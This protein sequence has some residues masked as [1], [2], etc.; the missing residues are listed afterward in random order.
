MRSLLSRRQPEFPSPDALIA[1]ADACVDR[2]LRVQRPSG[3][4]LYET[5]PNGDLQSEADSLVRQAGCAYALGYA[6]KRCSDATRAGSIFAA[7]ARTLCYL[8]DRAEH[9]AAGEFFIP[10]PGQRRG[11]LGTIALA[12]L[13]FHELSAPPELETF[14][15]QAAETIRSAQRPDGSFRCWLGDGKLPADGSKANYY[16][17]EAL[18]AL[19]RA[20]EVA[21]V[22]QS[23]SWARARFRVAP[24]PSF[25]GWHALVWSTTDRPEWAA[26]VFEQVDWLLRHQVRRSPQSGGFSF[27]RPPGAASIVYTEAVLGGLRAALTH[28]DARRAARYEAAAAR[29]LA[30]CLRLQLPP[31]LAHRNAAGGF[32]RNLTDQTVRCDNDQHALTALLTAAELRRAERV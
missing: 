13:A 7:A 11:K 9:S 26:F 23:F 14:A 24:E 15:Q 29:A 8:R 1:A 31:T 32:T 27:G 22:Q 5:H 3:A 6:A 2:L 16:P 25:V 21:A 19:A 12:A 4:F 17:G 20:S 18:L 30:F 10:E 28:G